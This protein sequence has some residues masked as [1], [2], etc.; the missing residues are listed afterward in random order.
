MKL[1]NYPTEY[2][3]DDQTVQNTKLATFVSLSI[4]MVVAVSRIV[5]KTYKTIYLL[6]ESKEKT[7]LLILLLFLKP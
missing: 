1:I 3:S 4:H 7:P 2:R 5:A 6:Q